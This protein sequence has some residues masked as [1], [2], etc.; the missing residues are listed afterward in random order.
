VRHLTERGVPLHAKPAAQM[1]LRVLVG[2][3][4][5]ALLIEMGYLTNADDERALT[6]GDVPSRLI[7][8]LLATISDARRGVADPDARSPRP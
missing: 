2:A 4:M 3:N 7:D 5:P 8:A 6:S 1:P